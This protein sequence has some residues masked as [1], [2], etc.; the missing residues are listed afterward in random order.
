M[1]TLMQTVDM[2]ISG[3][4]SFPASRGVRSALECIHGVAQVKMIPNER[5]VTVIYDA[6]RVSPHQFET[7]VRVMG[8][9]VERLIVRALHAPAMDEV[10]DAEVVAGPINRSELTHA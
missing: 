2:E 1:L 3:L 7:A 8:C 10:P 5:H 4:G 9:E 6:F